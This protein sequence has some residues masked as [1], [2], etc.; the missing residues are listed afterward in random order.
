MMGAVGVCVC[1]CIGMVY[2]K[3]NSQSRACKRNAINKIWKAII[4]TSKRKVIMRR[5]KGRQ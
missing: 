5:V 3:G 1:I 4:E 2:K